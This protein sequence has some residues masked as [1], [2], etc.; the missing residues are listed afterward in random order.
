[1]PGV[2]EHGLD[3]FA[4]EPTDL[5]SGV[6]R[7]ASIDAARSATGVLRH[8]RGE[9]DFSTAFDEGPAIVGFVRAD[10]PGWP[11]FLTLAEA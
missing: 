2:T 9:V 5:L 1:M 7:C 8:V 11:R 6:A 3:E 4:S 10:G